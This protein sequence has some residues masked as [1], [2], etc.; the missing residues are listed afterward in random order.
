MSIRYQ[1][2]TDTEAANSALLSVFESI[3]TAPLT[4]LRVMSLPESL[5][6][7][8]KTVRGV[9]TGAGCS[10]DCIAEIVLA[11]DEA[12]QNIIRH[13]YDE[14]GNGEIILSIFRVHDALCFSL[15]DFADCID[16]SRIRLRSLDDVRPGG[17]G[18]HLIHGCMD[19][20]AFV[21]PPAGAGNRFLM[22][23]RIE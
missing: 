15:V 10:G 12:C 8:R 20:A 7:V 6:R 14:S 2:W 9:A 16:V 3:D 23:K 21:V 22:I 18:M 4:E 13:A 17:L 11:V 19:S 1:D 5:R